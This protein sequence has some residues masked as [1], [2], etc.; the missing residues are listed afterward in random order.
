MRSAA[1]HAFRV[2]GVVYREVWPAAPIDHNPAASGGSKAACG[3]FLKASDSI[4][5]HNQKSVPGVV[6]FT[7]SVPGVDVFHPQSVP[8]V[9]ST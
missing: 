1:L 4:W 7:K 2:P 9:A 5:R 8:G 6:V 3:G